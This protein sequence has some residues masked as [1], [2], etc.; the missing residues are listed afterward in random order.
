MK[1]DIKTIL[2]TDDY[3]TLKLRQALNYIKYTGDD[4]YNAKDDVVED[5]K[6]KFLTFEDLKGI[7]EKETQFDGARSIIQLLPPP[8]FN[9]HIVIEA[10]GERFFM[11][12]MSS[13]EMQMVNTT[14]SLLYHLRNLDDKLKGDDK[15][16]YKNILVIL[17][18]VELYFHP[19]YQKKYVKYLRDQ[20]TNLNLQNIDNI[21]IVFVTHSPFILTD[22]LKMN[23]LYLEKGEPQQCDDESF[24]GNLY[25]LMHNSFFLRQNAMGDFAAEYVTKLVD[26]KN[27]GEILSDDETE[28]IGDNILRSY[29]QS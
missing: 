18:E 3:T 16:N 26:R 20:I 23:S 5:S 25:D 4:Y 15:I 7:I 14:G 17:E 13:G 8:I 10:D 6:C 24:A 19:E 21:N 2:S 27:A 28:I 29:L 11:T 1:D 22:I 12:S 9:G